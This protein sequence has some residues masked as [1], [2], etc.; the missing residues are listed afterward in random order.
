MKYPIW[1]TNA[2]TFLEWREPTDH[3]WSICY[4]SPF[5]NEWLDSVHVKGNTDNETVV[6][7][8][9]RLFSRFCNFTKLADKEGVLAEIKKTHV[10]LRGLSK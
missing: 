7:Q 2:L 6:R 4:V 9:N 1:Y 3:L 5:I 10:R 8:M